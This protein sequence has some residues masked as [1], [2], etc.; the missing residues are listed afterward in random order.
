MSDKYKMIVFN[1]VLTFAH[2][3]IDCSAIKRKLFRF[4]TVLMS[5]FDRCKYDINYA[6]CIM[7]SNYTKKS[8]S[9]YM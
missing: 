3:N 7:M 8:K 2:N 9:L 6:S 1:L 5:L 4:L